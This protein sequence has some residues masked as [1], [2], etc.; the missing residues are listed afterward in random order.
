MIEKD[1]QE[2]T[3][4]V[5]ALTAALTT[6]AAPVVVAEPTV[7][8]NEPKG[9]FYWAKANWLSFGFEQ[10]IEDFKRRLN[11]DASIM[12]IGEDDYLRLKAEAEKNLCEAVSPVLSAQPVASQAPVGPFYWSHPE[13]CSFGVVSDIAGLEAVLA[14]D[15]NTLE[16]DEQAYLRLKE[17]AAPAAEAPTP[18]TYETLRAAFQQVVEKRSTPVLKEILSKLGVE[19]A[20]HL[21]PEQYEEAMRLAQEA[22]Q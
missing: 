4:A 7:T 15:P 21:K 10:N 2:L 8:A 16:I 12:F 6:T 18:V 9:P 13:S 3:A 17:A 22:L 1:I 14:G 19:R 11:S 20:P 5:K